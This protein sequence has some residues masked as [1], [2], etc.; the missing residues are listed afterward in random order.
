MNCKLYRYFRNWGQLQKCDIKLLLAQE[1]QAIID[2]VFQN[3]GTISAALG[4]QYSGMVAG[5]SLA[6]KCMAQCRA[7]LLF[8]KTEYCSRCAWIPVLWDACFCHARKRRRGSAARDPSL[9]SADERWLWGHCRPL[10][11][12]RS[13]TLFPDDFR[14]VRRGD[15]AVFR[16]PSI[17]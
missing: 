4:S 5:S 8:D 2:R 17:A 6:R 11:I 12:R 3:A 14:Q 9:L 7:G 16:L 13:N 1:N 10:V 15:R